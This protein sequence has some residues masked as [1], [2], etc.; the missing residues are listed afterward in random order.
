MPFNID[1]FKALGLPFGGARPSLFDVT[2]TGPG[3]V[4]SIIQELTGAGAQDFTFKCKA[5]SLP[6]GNIDSIDAGYFGRKIKLAGDRTFQDWNV[7]VYNDEDFTAR[8]LFEAWSNAIN[9]IIE[10]K[11]DL[12]ADNEN[13]KADLLV[14]Q[15]AKNGEQLRQYMLV[16]AWPSSIEAIRL[17][18]ETTNQI[19]TFD[20]TMPYDY[21]IPVGEGNTKDGGRAP[22]YLDNT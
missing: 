6:M 4:T 22:K 13:Y 20:V 5:A 18:W 7:T 3:Q 9:R 1:E 12:R 19:E 15:W 10:N 17:D 8:A 21:W 11:R 14:T 2:L 16:G